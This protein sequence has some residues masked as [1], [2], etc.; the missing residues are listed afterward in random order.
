MFDNIKE[1]LKH[2]AIYGLGNVATKLVGFVLLPLYTAHITVEDYGILS[3]FEITMTILSQVLPVGQPQSYMR[4]YSLDEYEDQRGSLLFTNFIFLLGLAGV[5]LVVSYTIIPE[6]STYFKYSAE[7]STF[8]KIAFLVVFFRTL[9]KLISNHLRIKERSVLYAVSNTIKLIIT[10]T[11]NIYFV[12][13]AQIGVLGI[14]YAYLIGE[15]VFF[16]FLF[17]ILLKE[18]VPKFSWLITKESLKFGFPLIFTTLSGMLLNMGDRYVLKLLVNYEEVGLY[19]LG[20]KIAGVLNMLFIQAFQLGMLPMAYKMYGK[21]GDKRFY[22]KLQTYFVFI[23]SWAGLALAL[24]SKELLHLLALNPDYWAAY[25][26]VPIIILGYILSGAKYNASMLLYLTKKTQYTAYL[27]FS[28]AVLNI[29]LNFLLI[30]DLKM[31]GAG[32]ATVISFLYLFIASYLVGK[33]YYPVKYEVKKL[34]YSIGLAILFFLIA[35][36]L[37][38]FG[39]II[40]LIIKFI[41]VGVYPFILYWFGFYESQE[42]KRIKSA[43]KKLKQGDISSIIK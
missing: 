12:A 16:I 22:T 17:P 37:Q 14:L 27:T 3:I 1:T 6:I 4:F 34:I 18:M 30:P 40:T 29:G 25:T 15:V 20:Y 10:L 28:G 24:F 38:H 23:L 32:V 33:K 35:D 9:S 26:V 19:N 11:G 43:V 31:I 2:S 36:N 7:F 39:V 8:F 41:L 5:F 21:D 13:I 42:L